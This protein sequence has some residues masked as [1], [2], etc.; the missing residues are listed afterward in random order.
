MKLAKELLVGSLPARFQT[1]VQTVNALTDVVLY[2]LGLDYYSGYAKRV[3]TVSDAQVQASAKK[4]LVPE[5]M[6]VVAVGDRKK[7]ESELK[8]LG[9]GGIQ[10]RDAEG[11]VISR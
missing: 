11:K 7:I 1:T 2:D 10:V 4:Y 6:V 9:L 8:T 3:R 5:K